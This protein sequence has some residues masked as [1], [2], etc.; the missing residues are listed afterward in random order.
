[1]CAVHGK[2]TSQLSMQGSLHVVPVFCWDMCYNSDNF[3]LCVVL[4]WGE[5]ILKMNSQEWGADD[6]VVLSKSLLIAVQGCILAIML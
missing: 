5:C 2:M 1:M 4:I 3:I 6:K